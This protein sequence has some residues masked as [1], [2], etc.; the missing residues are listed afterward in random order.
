MR[1]GS[2]DE[3]AF[4]GCPRAMARPEAGQ[5]I[6]KVAKARAGGLHPARAGGRTG[7]ARAAGQLPQDTGLRPWR[8]PGG[9]KT[10]AR[11]GQR[12]SGIAHK[13]AR[14][15]ARQG[16]AGLQRTVVTD[17]GAGKTGRAPL[18]GNPEPRR[19]GLCPAQSPAAKGGGG[20]NVRR[21]GSGRFGHGAI[22]TLMLR[23]SWIAASMA[24]GNS[25]S[26]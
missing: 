26:G 12:R 9:T 5:R 23:R 6:R 1:T 24:T 3:T 11:L 19:T 21:T 4:R 8:G 10:P 16:R 22:W 17:T 2:C 25:A 13:R 20:D 15:K 18:R 7:R 14:R